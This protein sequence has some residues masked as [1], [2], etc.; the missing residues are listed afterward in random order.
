MTPTDLTPLPRCCPR[1]D[2]YRT[3]VDHLIT[4]FPEVTADEVQ[5]QTVRARSAIAMVRLTGEDELAIAELIARY[6]LSYAAGRL[7]DS[8]RLDPQPHPTRRRQPV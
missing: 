7:D 5:E 8:A 2:S 4:D 3:L 1:H 6:Q